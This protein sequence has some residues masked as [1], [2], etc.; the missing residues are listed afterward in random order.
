[1][2]QFC[3]KFN[4]QSYLNAVE[5]AGKLGVSLPRVHT[6]EL[7]DGAFSFPRI[8]RYQFVQENMDMLEHFEDNLNTNISNS[9]NVA[10]FIKVGKTVVA[11]LNAKYHD[12]EF[13]DPASFDP[14]DE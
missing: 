13:V 6:W 8:R 9:I 5:I 11:N 10:N 4:K 14:R 2:D 3:R 1:M 7:L 12:G